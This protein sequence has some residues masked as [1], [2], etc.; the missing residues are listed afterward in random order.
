[1]YNI[2]DYIKKNRLREGLLVLRLAAF[3][4]EP[5]FFYKARKSVD[6]IVK[7]YKIKNAIVSLY[8][9]KVQISINEI[10]RRIRNGKH[11]SSKA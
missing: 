4:E 9:I 10:T 1:M 6:M 3:Y 8:H 2:N 11:Y 7:Y 5:F